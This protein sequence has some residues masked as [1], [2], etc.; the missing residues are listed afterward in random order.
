MT[1]KHI[2]SI[3]LVRFGHRIDYKIWCYL[4]IIL[5]LKIFAAFKRGEEDHDQDQKIINIHAV[6]RSSSHAKFKESNR[7]IIL[8]ENFN[9]AFEF[10]MQFIQIHHTNVN[11]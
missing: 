6:L 9:S 7:T 1:T 4:I 2:A 3:Y 11:E 5:L 8:H 10:Q